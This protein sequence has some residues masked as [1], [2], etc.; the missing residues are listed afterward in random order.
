GVPYDSYTQ[1]LN[2]LLKQL[3]AGTKARIVMANIPDLTLLPDF[4]HSSA[5]Q[6]ATMLTAIKKWNSAIASIA[7]RYGVTL[8]DLFS[9]ESQ[10]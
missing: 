5:S 6:K 9:H 7:A 3:R 2:S 4:S 8:V 10:L 1:D